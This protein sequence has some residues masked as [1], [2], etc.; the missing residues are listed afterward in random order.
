MQ[1]VPARTAFD[2]VCNAVLLR[3]R[4][5]RT[6]E[7]VESSI[8]SLLVE[9]DVGLRVYLGEVCIYFR[10][11]KDANVEVRRD[12]SVD[13]HSVGV[14]RFEVLA[15]PSSSDGD[16]GTAM[17]SGVRNLVALAFEHAVKSQSL[18]SSMVHELTLILTGT[19]MAMRSLESNLVL[20]EEE[21]VRTDSLSA[22]R[23]AT[24]AI[25][26][27]S[28]LGLYTVR[29]FLSHVTG[30]Q[31]VQRSRHPVDL[32]DILDEL[33]GL[34]SASRAAATS[35]S[36]PYLGPRCRWSSERLT[37]FDGRSITS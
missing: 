1:V 8:A 34:H 12:T 26:A 32:N 24:D 30:E 20:L 36:K 29:N 11:T 2:Q 33:H 13:I 21:G 37:S 14:L 10:P 15:N 6:W 7:V 5:C 9:L 22:A 25:L 19:G 18:A 17:L 4:F 3:E 23:E 28:Q 31:Q 27:E 35:S 16:A